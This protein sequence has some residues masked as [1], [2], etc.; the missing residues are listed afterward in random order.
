MSSKPSLRAKP[1]TFGQPLAY[2]HPHLVKRN[3]L[4]PGIP[5][6]DYMDRRRRLMDRLPPGSIVVCLGAP[7][8]YMSA[9]T[10]RYRPDSDLWYLT[11]FEEP[12]VALILEKK[13]SSRG[14]WMT[15]F[16]AGERSESQGRWDGA[17]TSFEQSKLM[18]DVDDVQS[19]TKFP[20][21]L[22]SRYSAASYIYTEAQIPKK[23]VGSRLFDKYMPR[24]DH[25][26]GDFVTALGRVLDVIPVSK[27]RQL[28]PQIMP[29]RA[30]KSL[31]EQAV[32]RRAGQISGRAHAKVMRFTEEGLSEAD[33]EAH[34]EYICRRAGAQRLAYV[35]VVGSGPNGCIIH[36][37]SNN[38]LV[39]NGELVTIDAA[40][41]Y[42]GYASDITR[43]YPVSGEFTPP[44]RDI[45]SAVLAAQ[46]QLIAECDLSLGNSLQDLHARSCDLLRQELNQL[47]GFN[48]SKSDLTRHLYPHYLSHPLGIDLH[49][50]QCF[51]RAARLQEGIVITIEPGVY[52]PPTSRFPKHYHNIGIRIEDMVLITQSGPVVLSAEAPK[53]IVD[54]EGACQG[55]LGLEAF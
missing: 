18:F 37:T 34:F 28:A 15:L 39:K 29:L 30:I 7:I 49:E 54:V 12:D 27:V 42:N 21:A 53:E 52:V 35:P 5:R 24:M 55:I 13:S 10:Y 6:E 47:P 32:M 36:Y 8:K 51:D 14:Y 31:S 11:G 4:T 17:R 38:Q 50:S 3:E 19:I 1:T 23:S 20:S 44:Q 33:I 9:S 26:P 25:L 2:S 22:K 16:C 40:C 43:S 46:R 41:E 48:L 45:Y